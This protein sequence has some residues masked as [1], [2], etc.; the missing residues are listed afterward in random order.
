MLVVLTFAAMP[1]FGF[2]VHNRVANK[3][4]VCT[5]VPIKLL[6]VLKIYSMHFCAESKAPIAPRTQ[7]IWSH[8]LMS[9]FVR[10][11]GMRRRQRFA[12]KNRPW[13]LRQYQSARYY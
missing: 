13:H 8:E 2:R 5:S 10:S 4:I 6:Y 7:G 11:L 12:I 9:S 1:I 3:Y